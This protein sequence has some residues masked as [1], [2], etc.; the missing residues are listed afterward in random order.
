MPYDIRSHK[1]TLFVMSTQRA[2]R[3][4]YSDADNNRALDKCMTVADFF[5]RSVVVAGKKRA[6]EAMRAL[7]LKKAC[8]LCDA[9]TLSIAEEFFVFFKNHS[10][11]S[12]FLKECSCEFLDLD[13]LGELDFYEEYREHINILKCVLEKYNLLL[14]ENELFDEITVAREWSLN[15]SFVKEFDCV[16]IFVDGLL[17]EFEWR[18]LHATAQMTRLLLSVKIDEYSSKLR[19]R[20]LK[21]GIELEVG[22]AY[23][24]DLCAKTTISKVPLDPF[25]PASLHVFSNR[26]AQIGWVKCQLS[27]W[28]SKKGYD[29]AKIAVVLPDESAASMLY[30]FDGERNLN[31]AQGLPFERTNIVRNLRAICDYMANGRG[32]DAKRIRDLGLDAAY[33][34]ELSA[35]WSKPSGATFVIERLEPLF[36]QCDSAQQK[37]ILSQRSYEFCMQLQGSFEMTFGQLCSLF[38]DDL[39]AQSLDDV[40]GGPVTVLGV[41]ETRFLKLDAVI[42]MDCNEGLV[43]KSSIKD[44][45]LGDALKREAGIPTSADREELQKH[46]YAQLFRS[47]KEVAIGFVESSHLSASKMLLEFGLDPSLASRKDYTQA[48]FAQRA[49]APIAL[50]SSP[51]NIEVELAQYPLSASKLRDYLQCRF[52]FWLKYIQKIDDAK[53]IEDIPTDAQIGTLL[54]AALKECMSGAAVPSSSDDLARRLHSALQKSTKNEPIWEFTTKLWAARLQTFCEHEFS[55]L[56]EG[57]RVLALETKLQCVVDGVTLDGYVDRIDIK[58]GKLYV[59]DYKSGSVTAKAAGDSLDFQL[60]I[61]RE[62]SSSMKAGEVDGAWWYELSSGKLHAEPQPQE[63]SMLLREA[64]A[65]YKE[66]IQSFDRTD[67]RSR[68]RFCPYMVLCGIDI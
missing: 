47:A 6:E 55:R 39:C 50:A 40:S 16:H 15:G 57:F 24:I 27:E 60:P 8:E 18:I 21:S 11:I 51:Q 28:V 43:P 58:E 62:L 32:I 2:I 30:D 48:L 68:C 53:P 31:F 64:L 4:M 22:F 66:P 59:L 5:E 10:Y 29:P 14:D 38:L 3:Q 9:K 54:H 12:G 35:L 63:A 20:L 37:R 42:V 26:I 19:E 65:L 17:S 52:R 7:L 67:V 41:L 44:M 34:E 25:A 49:V 61:Y 33:V 56:Q 13:L 23:D 36:L 46:Y 1:N 45:V